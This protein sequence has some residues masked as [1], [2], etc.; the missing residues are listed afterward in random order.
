MNRMLIG[1]KIFNPQT[2]SLEEMPQSFKSDYSQNALF[3]SDGK[4]AI[5]ATDGKVYD[6]NG[7]LI[8]SFIFN[9]DYCDPNGVNVPD[10]SRGTGYSEF[11]FVKTPFGC[12]EFYAIAVCSRKLYVKNN[13]KSYG[14]IIYQKLKYN[15]IG[16]EVIPFANG[17][18]KPTVITL[19]DCEYLQTECGAHIKFNS[20]A[21]GNPG[22]D[23]SGRRGI[24]EGESGNVEEGDPNIAM[25]D[26]L[27]HSAYLEVTK[28]QSNGIRYLFTALDGCLNLFEIK[29]D[30][31]YFKSNITSSIN[32]FISTSICD[33]DW[34][35]MNFDQAVN[36]TPNINP[37]I[38]NYFRSRIG[39]FRGEMDLIQISNESIRLAI[40]YMGYADFFDK[41]FGGA[42]IVVKSISVTG[43]DVIYFN[44]IN[45]VPT[46]QKEELLGI[47]YP[48]STAHTN[49]QH[50]RRLI[51]GLEFSDN[52]SFLYVSSVLLNYNESQTGS[53]AKIMPSNILD[54]FSFDANSNCYSNFLSNGGIN[55]K[56][57]LNSVLPFDYQDIRN[58]NATCDINRDGSFSISQDNQFGFGQIERDNF[59]RLIISNEK[60]LMAL[61]DI[62]NPQSPLAIIT[63]PQTP[64]FQN[65]ISTHRKYKINRLNISKKGLPPINPAPFV[66]TPSTFLLP[67]QI[68]GENYSAWFSPIIDLYPES[69]IIFPNPLF[70][71]DYT[72]SPHTIDLYKGTS[73]STAPVFYNKLY[74]DVPIT[75]PANVF[76]DY[77]KWTTNPD[78]TLDA[79]ITKAIA[80][81]TQN[82]GIYC[83]GK[84]EINILDLRHKVYS[85]FNYNLQSMIGGPITPWSNGNYTSVN[86]ILEEGLFPLPLEFKNC[87]RQEINFYEIDSLTNSRLSPVSLNIPS[88]FTYVYNTPLYT[89]GSFEL[90]Y[91][92]CFDNCAAANGIGVTP[93]CN[94]TSKFFN[95]P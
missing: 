65:T 37:E 80:T 45:G 41:P 84:E 25:Q 58:Q 61:S 66:I 30:D 18:N 72:N 20:D 5:Y 34:Y 1:D 77:F 21:K 49:T 43:V 2:N 46:Y 57:T 60:N 94:I 83:A 29:S 12:N 38:N 9:S 59:N 4:L 8:T 81:Y 91:K 19:M 90:E 76:G 40:P 95:I 47:D 82:A 44:L 53:L 92:V 56:N 31:I 15:G 6:W 79:P 69:V 10:Q 70:P 75:P 71:R 16:W 13:E 86:W 17:C 88:A 55:L 68:T 50:K 27:E 36:P 52:G 62:N 63:L 22:N 35:N 39:A 85:A 23:Y 14:G 89:S 93:N 24:R 11:I 32:A 28:E 26:E 73:S 74:F 78:Y 87:V 51:K 54:A 67:D 3:F 64:I 42:S 7:N 33:D 48:S